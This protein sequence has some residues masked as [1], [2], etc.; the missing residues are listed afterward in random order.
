MVY[1]LRP[2]RAAP[3]PREAGPL[4]DD[5]PRLAEAMLCD[6]PPLRDEPLKPLLRDGDDAPRDMLA[7]LLREGVLT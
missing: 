7:L 2:P 6:M 4:C 1:Y 5:E 3:P